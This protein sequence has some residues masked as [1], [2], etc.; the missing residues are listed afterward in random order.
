M[1][2]IAEVRGLVASARGVGCPFMKMSRACEI[3]PRDEVL[4]HQLWRVFADL[5]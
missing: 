2:Q 5:S 3:A 4:S 1:S